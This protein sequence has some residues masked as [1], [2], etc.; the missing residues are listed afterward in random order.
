MG[1]ALAYAFA[2]PALAG[3]PVFMTLGLGLALPFLLI[4]FVPA[5]ARRLPKPGAWME[6]LKQLLAYP[7]YL[8]A[9]W[10]LWVLGH[11]RGVDAV[12]LVLAGAA[13][14]ALALG[15]F[16]R[17]RW[18][19]RRLATALSLGALPGRAAAGW[20]VTRL[21]P[22]AAT[23]RA[24]DAGVVAYSPEGLARLRAANQVVFV[25]MTADWCVTCKANERNVLSSDAF[26]ALLERTGAT[27]MHGDWTNAD[28]AISAFLEEHRAVGVPL[29]VVYGPGAPPAVLPPVL[30]PGPRRGRAAA[31]RGPMKPAARLLL[32]AVAA[33]AAGLLAGRWYGHRP[34]Q[35]R[36]AGPHAA[37]AVPAGVHPARVGDPLP[38]IRLPGLDGKIVELAAI[39]R[40]AGRCW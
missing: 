18:Q 25:N 37:P 19:G 39:A 38:A 9:I 2:A 15:W 35:A 20:A 16:E 12:A 6:T 28:P 40:Q 32:V 24:Q 26:R 10:L 23:V 11:Q 5:L 22:P 4:G 33:G 30:T 21:A 8:T 36:D 31:R 27:Y 14:L 29:Y 17:S 3:V 13:L 34:P 1:P 7:M